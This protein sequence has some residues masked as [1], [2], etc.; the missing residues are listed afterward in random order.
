MVWIVSEGAHPPRRDIDPVIPM[1][2][3]I[4]QTL[5]E[6]PLSLDQRDAQIGIRI[7]KEVSGKQNTARAASDNDHRFL[8]RHH[9]AGSVTGRMVL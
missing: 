8:T 9:F 4:C 3:R 2:S 7:A 6:A 1:P 5:T